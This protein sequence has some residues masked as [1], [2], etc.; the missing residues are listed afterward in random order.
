M[1]ESMN[2]NHNSRMPVVSIYRSNHG[3]KTAGLILLGL[4]IKKLKV[5]E[6]G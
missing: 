1:F 3:R 6:V 5:K 4:Q 2:P